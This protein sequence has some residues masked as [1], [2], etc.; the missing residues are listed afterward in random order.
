MEERLGV[1][2]RVMGTVP[3]STLVEV[4]A[5][6]ATLPDEQRQLIAERLN[7]ITRDHLGESDLAD[8]SLALLKGEASP[9]ED[10]RFDAVYEVARI[11]TNF[12]RNPRKLSPL[13]RIVEDYH[14]E[15]RRMIPDY[16]AKVRA[17]AG[18]EAD[19]VRARAE[20][21]R[22]AESGAAATPGYENGI[23]TANDDGTARVT[24]A[25]GAG[26]AS[27]PPRNEPGTVTANDDGTATVAYA[28]GAGEAAIAES[29]TPGASVA[30][31]HAAT[32]DKTKI[33]RFYATV[34]GEG[35]LDGMDADWF[36]QQASDLTPVLSRGGSLLQELEDHSS[37]FDFQHGEELSEGTIVEVVLD[38]GGEPIDQYPTLFSDPVSRGL[39]KIVPVSPEKAK[40]IESFL[41]L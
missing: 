19:Y 12:G 27:A 4:R 11:E 15:L 33:N 2:P 9:D 29:G 24:Y 28:G 13:H 22:A 18:L 21:Y 5:A 6:I 1:N 37:T 3:P 7:R 40:E 36:D 34:D 38:D 31:N 20:A 10:V 35:G 17:D 32:V 39:L 26:E 14:D 25:G 8:R 30:G 41:S 23:V 16:Y